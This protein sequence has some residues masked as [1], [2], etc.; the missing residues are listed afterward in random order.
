V[1]NCGKLIVYWRLLSMAHGEATRLVPSR[2]WAEQR[3]LDQTT[4]RPDGAMNL[5]IVD[6]PMNG[7]F[8][9][10]N[11]WD[12][13]IYITILTPMLPGYHYTWGKC[14]G[15]RFRRNWAQFQKKWSPVPSYIFQYEDLGAWGWC[16]TCLMEAAAGSFIRLVSWTH[17]LPSHCH[18]QFSA[19]YV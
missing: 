6:L 18:K 14:C 7:D 11:S 17:Q 9:Y 8:P 4:G 16:Q 5:F 19:V 12:I 1:L 13:Y 15:D 10:R 2:P 3:C